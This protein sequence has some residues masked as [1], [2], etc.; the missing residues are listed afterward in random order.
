MKEIKNEQKLLIYLKK[1]I[2]VSRKECEGGV[3]EREVHTKISFV[4]FFST[5]LRV[6]GFRQRLHLFLRSCS[7]GRFL[8]F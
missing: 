7:F 5:T 6:F 8:L 2:A 3:C 1:K 4:S